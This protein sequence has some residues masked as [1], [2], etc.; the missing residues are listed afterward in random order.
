MRDVEDNWHTVPCP[1]EAARAVERTGQVKDGDIVVALIGG[2]ETTLKRFY[3]EPGE[4]A[5]LQPANS[6]LKP[7]FVARKDLVPQSPAASRETV[8]AGPE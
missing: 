4:M 1:R 6:S 7:I 2:S 8:L 5:R 3:K